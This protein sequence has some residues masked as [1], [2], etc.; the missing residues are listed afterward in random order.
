MT[1][2]PRKIATTREGLEIRYFDNPELRGAKRVEDMLKSAERVL[3]SSDAPTVDE[4]LGLFKALQA[5]GYLVNKRGRKPVRRRRSIRSLVDLYQRIRDRLVRQNIGLVYEM[6]RRTR[7]VDVDVDELTSEGFWALFQAVT[8]FD[9]WRGF[10]FST[11]AC[12]SI[13][14]GALLLAKKHRRQREQL[15]RLRDGAVDPE[16][17]VH[18]EREGDIDRGVL[19]ERLRHV[20]SREET[21]LTPT[22]RFVLERRLLQPA[23]S[24][25]E[26]LESIGDYFQL[27]KERVR[28]IQIAAVEKVRGAL[29]AIEPAESL[30]S[31][32]TPVHEEMD[33][34]GQPWVRQSSRPDDLMERRD[35][36]L[37]YA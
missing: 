22:E 30:V 7:V 3:A 29:T 25:P 8:R 11:Y 37:V 35:L 15:Q 1:T 6:R 16:R 32:E 33:D 12:T 34:D 9:P 27:S 10:R 17:A 28:Q 5:C 26:T 20:L 13:L 2:V 31:F 23:G 4:E 18:R 24:K 14:H 19:V 21:G 36:D